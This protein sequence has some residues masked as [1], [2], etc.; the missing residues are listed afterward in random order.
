MSNIINSSFKDY[1]NLILII[2]SIIFVT[3]II[4]TIYYNFNKNI[5]YKILIKIIIILILIKILLLSI[6]YNLNYTKIIIFIP[7][8]T[9]I[10]LIFKYLFAVKINK[11]NLSLIIVLNLIILVLHINQRVYTNNTDKQIKNFNLINFILITMTII[12]I[13]NN[14]LLLIIS[15]EVLNQILYF[16]NVYLIKKIDNYKFNNLILFLDKICIILLLIIGMILLK[17]NKN[18]YLENFEFISKYN[19]IINFNLIIILII[20]WI[21]IVIYTLL[22]N[23]AKIKFKQIY[24]IYTVIPLLT[25][26]ILITKFI[27]FLN[28]NYYYFIIISIT[29]IINIINLI[30]MFLTR[31]TNIIWIWINVVFLNHMLINFYI[32]GSINM[33]INNIII[34]N[35]LINI[36]IFFAINTFY[37]NNK[38]YK[39]F[40]INFKFIAILI[41]LLFIQLIINY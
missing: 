7:I 18:L 4:L 17:F 33:L 21:Q 35:N 1:E 22:I 19:N 41:L 30:L 12:I 2:Y 26:T 9:N 28:N 29:L 13:S 23:F 8:K 25:N 10:N 14:Q 40:D 31:K 38:L 3:I 34:I 24:F 6:I 37:I 39:S 32:I 5:D 15:L 36:I 20:K 27:Y 11:I 16:K